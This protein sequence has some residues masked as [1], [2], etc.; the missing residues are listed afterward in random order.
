[1]H[2]ADRK[3]I[4]FSLVC[5]KIGFRTIEKNLKFPL[6]FYLADEEIQ[7]KTEWEI[8]KCIVEVSSNSLPRAHVAPSIDFLQHL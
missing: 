4:L 8:S 6:F 5:I 1:M 3:K 2:I 7:Q